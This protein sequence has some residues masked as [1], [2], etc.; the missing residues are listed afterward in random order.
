MREE[1][2]LWYGLTENAQEGPWYLAKHFTVVLTRAA[3]DASSV[4]WGGVLRFASLV[5]QAGADFGP[6]WMARDIHV[7]EMYALHE[8][9]Q[10]FCKEFPGRLARAQVVADVDNLTVVHNFRKGRA[11]DATFHRLLRALFDL[12]MREGFWLRLR[13]IPSEANVEADSIT[14]PGPNLCV[15]ALTYLQSCGRFLGHSISILRLHPCLPTASR[16]PRRERAISSHALRDM[17]VKVPREWI[18]FR[19]TCRESRGSRRARSVSAFPQ[20]HWPTQP[21]SISQSN[22]HMR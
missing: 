7:E 21:C 3:S 11:R 13:W 19:K 18:F 15:F 5:F 17:R 8:L 14:R 4:A 2:E 1:L 16:R 9:L 20:P 22:E 10:V 12:Q 6:E